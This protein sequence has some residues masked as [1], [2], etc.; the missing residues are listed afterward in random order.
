MSA[1]CSS[2][3]FENDN[4]REWLCKEFVQCSELVDI[5]AECAL[6]SYSSADSFVVTRHS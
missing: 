2:V 1:G 6:Q 3:R 5:S 4:D